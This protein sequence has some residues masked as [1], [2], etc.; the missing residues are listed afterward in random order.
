MPVL[1]VIDVSRVFPS[2]GGRGRQRTVMKDP[3][4]PP[5]WEGSLTSMTLC[6]YPD[7]KMNINGHDRESQQSM[8]AAAECEN[9]GGGRF[10]A[11]TFI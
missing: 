4:H 10:F 5:S 9:L 11:D 3:F 1:N 8:E 7:E 2:P 6:R